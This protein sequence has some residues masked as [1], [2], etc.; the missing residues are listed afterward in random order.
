MDGVNQARK[1]LLVWHTPEQWSSTTT[2]HLQSCKLHCGAQEANALGPTSES[3]IFWNSDT[4]YSIL[5]FYAVICLITPRNWLVT[6]VYSCL[7]HRL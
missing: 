4:A 3:R 7:M 6:L 2:A 5:L 1:S